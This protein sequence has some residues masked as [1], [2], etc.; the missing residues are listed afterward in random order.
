M[1]LVKLINRFLDFSAK[2]FLAVA[3]ALVFIM[4]AINVANILARPLFGK[5]LI[6]VFPWTGTIFVWATFL[7]FF[8]IFRRGQDI[9]IDV[10]TRRFTSHGQVVCE[11]LMSI[12]VVGFLVMLL[13]QASVLIPRQVGTIDM[14]G[15]QRYWL[16]IPFFVSCF[17]IG[18]HLINRI[19]VLII[20]L[21][22]GTETRPMA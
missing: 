14:V 13:W 18:L 19:I 4:L 3:N 6:W 15:I 9:T 17:M 21:R 5:G 1:K 16:S 7:A 11:I 8:V 2:T 12:I 20:E 22:R 10:L